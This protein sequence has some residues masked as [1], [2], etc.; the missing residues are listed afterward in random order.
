MT[1]DGVGSLQGDGGFDEMGYMKELG[2]Q[3]RTYDTRW[4]RESAR[5]WGT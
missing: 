5:I 4:S 2:E 1:Q 3:R